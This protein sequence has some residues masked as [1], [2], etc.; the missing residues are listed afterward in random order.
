MVSFGF[1]YF[2]V[3]LISTNKYTLEPFLF[4]K[5]VAHGGS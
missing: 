4:L 1:D 3:L 2:H 5:E